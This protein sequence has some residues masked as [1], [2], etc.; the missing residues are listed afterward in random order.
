MDENIKATPITFGS[1]LGKI[2]VALWG[3][4]SLGFAS[5]NFPQN[6][7]TASSGTP[8]STPIEYPKSRT[9]V[10]PSGHVI[11]FNDTPAG[12]RVLVKHRTGTAVDMLPDGTMAISS[13]GKM[14]FTVRSDMSIEVHGDV[15]WSV[16]GNF[17]LD[18][19]G[20]FNVKALNIDTTAEGAINHTATSGSI[21]ITAG[22]NLREVVKGSKSTT[23]LSSITTLALGDISTV[24]QGGQ[25][26]VSQGAMQ[27]AGGSSSKI[28]TQGTMDISAPNMNIGANSMTVIGS[29]GTIGG[30]GITMYANN[31]HAQNTVLAVAMQATTFHGDLIGTAAQSIQS[32]V[33]GGLSAVSIGPLTNVSPSVQGTALP[34]GALMTDYLTM[35]SKGIVVVNVDAD[36]EIRR[37]IDRSD[38][39]GGISRNSMTTRGVRSALRDEANLSNAEFT[40]N[41]IANGTLSPTYASFTPPGVNRAS[42]LDPSTYLGNPDMGASHAP[43][44]IKPGPKPS[45]RSFLPDFNS[46][47]SQTTKINENTI[48][49]DGIRLS[50]FLREL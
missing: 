26:V 21:N 46:Y 7:E 28:S 39:N 49:L 8:S 29:T 40:N 17:N 16:D 50:T 37:A 35:S 11:Q 13:R 34:N 38:F 32:A 5:L 10:T 4:S 24:S 41:Q 2:P 6:T 22:A 18:V 12:E 36:G 30:E 19:K 20:N 15:S 25:K 1:Q 45:R 44:W 27:I 23:A 14:I 47:I 43:A 42:P 9:N 31:I 3:G 48:L 33:A